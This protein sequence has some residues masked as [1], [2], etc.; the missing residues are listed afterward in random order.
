MGVAAISLFLKD[1]GQKRAY[2]QTFSFSLILHIVGK[3]EEKV[4]GGGLRIDDATA[5]FAAWLRQL[6]VH[7]VNPTSSN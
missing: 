2:V 5:A 3:N 7:L 4:E 6:P 1:A